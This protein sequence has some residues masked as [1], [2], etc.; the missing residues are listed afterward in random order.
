M[1]EPDAY[2]EAT[3]LVNLVCLQRTKYIKSNCY[4]VNNVI[5]CLDN[6]SLDMN[7]NYTEYKR[8]DISNKMWM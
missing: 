4:L 7:T 3:A 2:A 6:N 5:Y 1:Q 8:F